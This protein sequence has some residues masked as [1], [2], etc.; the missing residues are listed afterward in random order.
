LIRFL[1]GIR[2]SRKIIP[3]PRFVLIFAV[4]HPLRALREASLKAG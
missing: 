4:P 1:L 3:A 2:G